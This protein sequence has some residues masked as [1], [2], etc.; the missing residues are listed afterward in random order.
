[1]NGLIQKYV[2]KKSFTQYHDCGSYYVNLIN[3]KKKDK[4]PNQDKLNFSVKFGNF[5]LLVRF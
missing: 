2:E 4:T 3:L 5:L 1:M